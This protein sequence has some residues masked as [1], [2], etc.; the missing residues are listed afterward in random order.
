M[1]Q[2]LSTSTRKLIGTI[3]LLVSL[4]VVPG[5]GTAIYLTWLQGQSP[6]VLIVFFAIAGLAWLAPAMGI[7]RWMSRPD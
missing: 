5:I 1:T 2:A 4:V 7:I 6:V 3:L